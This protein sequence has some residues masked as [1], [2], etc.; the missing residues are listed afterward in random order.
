MFDNIEP[1]GEQ[2]I[3][4]D[5]KASWAADSPSNTVTEF[6]E[7]HFHNDGSYGFDSYTYDKSGQKINQTDGH[8]LNGS[9]Q[10]SLTDYG[11]EQQPL[12]GGK[13]EQAG[14]NQFGGMNGAQ[15]DLNQ[16]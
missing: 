6:S 12:I 1:F 4:A 13:L 14:Q 8:Q 5:N 11:V 16:F 9:G 7:P 3:G 2:N 10:R 15:Q